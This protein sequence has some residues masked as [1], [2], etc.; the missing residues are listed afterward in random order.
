[1]IIWIRRL[2]IILIT[3]VFSPAAFASYNDGD[4][5]IYLIL[6][7]AKVEVVA[8]IITLVLVYLGKFKK[9][10]NLFAYDIALCICGFGAVL[11]ADGDNKSVRIALIRESV[12]LTVI[13]LPAIIQYLWWRKKG[14]SDS[15][16]RAV[17]R[18]ER[19]DGDL[20]FLGASYSTEGN[21]VI[22]GQEIGDAVEA[23]FGYREYEWEWTINLADLPRLSELLH[24]KSDLLPALEDR[25]RGPAA[26]QLGK[27]LQECSIPYEIW[28]RIGD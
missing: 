26:A 18:D 11:F 4:F 22:R 9:S 1:M 17:L 5:G 24:S 2:C 3:S 27:F 12:L 8:F 14:D 23:I 10:T 6:I 21:L 15:Q 19:T 20:R 13:L 7:S 28:T 25:F 16:P